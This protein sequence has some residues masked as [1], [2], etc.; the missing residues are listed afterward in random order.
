VIE[1]LNGGP[2]DQLKFFHMATMKIAGETYPTLRHGMAGAPGLEIWGPYAS[3]ERVRDTILEAGAE[4][5]LLPVG[6]RAY[7]SN[8]LESGWI[9]SPLPAVYSSEA[10][11]AYRQWLPA[12]S[13]EATQVLSGSFVSEDIEDYYTTPYDLGYGHIIKFDHDFIGRDALEDWTP[14]SSARR[15]R[16]R[17]TPKT[18]ARS[19]PRYLTSRGPATRSSTCPTPTT[20]RRTS[21]P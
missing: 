12:N 21:T 11:R 18:W 10:E 16:W 1:K 20:A 14:R 4:F 17:G 8:T 2:V 3:Y 13:Y 7:S 19:S 15:S 9:P 5:G 6:S